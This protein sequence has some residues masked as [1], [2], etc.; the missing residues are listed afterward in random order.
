ME[1]EKEE[2][3]LVVFQLGKEEYGVEVSQV[4]EIIKMKEITRIPNQPEFI[5]GLINLRGQIII[6][7]DLR[8]RFLLQD[9]NEIRDNARI[10]IVEFKDHIIGMIVDSVSEVLRLS[11][12]N[13]G[14]IPNIKSNINKEYLKGVGKI[15]KRILILLDL[16][17]ILTE[18]E[19][20][21]VSKVEQKTKIT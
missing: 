2:I 15:G 14:E 19:I 8:K 1:E 10:I 20:E 21:Q 11:T 7:I 5:E 18:L 12:E 9:K 6:V 13:I 16:N 3:P 4:R 17:K